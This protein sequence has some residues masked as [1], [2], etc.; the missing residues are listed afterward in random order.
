[1]STI[2]EDPGCES[3]L[4]QEVLEDDFGRPMGSTR[5]S[6]EDLTENNVSRMK[7]RRHRQQEQRN[8]DSRETAC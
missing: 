5:H 6:F 8:M 3:H 2:L 4:V 7:A 1:M